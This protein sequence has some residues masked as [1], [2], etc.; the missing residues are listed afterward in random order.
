VH[1]ESRT[2]CRRGTLTD[3]ALTGWLGI[4]H[5]EQTQKG[6]SFLLAWLRLATSS[7]ARFGAAS[8][9]CFV[10]AYD[11]PVG[12]AL[13]AAI[14]TAVIEGLRVPGQIR[15]RISFRIICL[16]RSTAPP[17]VDDPLA[18]SAVCGSR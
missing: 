12:L 4:P 2:P 9:S 11:R 17:I 15:I 16:H 14:A 5:L 7:L 8:V 10:N 3:F 13:V 1:A 6:G 18:R